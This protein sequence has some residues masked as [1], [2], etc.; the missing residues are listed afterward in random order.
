M[1]KSPSLHEMVKIHFDRIA[2][3]F[4]AAILF[5]GYLATLSPD[6]QWLDSSELQ[7]A[8][9]LLDNAHPPGEPL[10]AIIAHAMRFVPMGSLAFRITVFS[11]LCGVLSLLFVYA[12]LMQIT[13]LVLKKI[14]WQNRILA[15]GLTLFSAFSYALWVQTIRS[16]VYSLNFLLTTAI[17]YLSIR[18]LT[19]VISI[20]QE[21]NKDIR[22]CR[23]FKKEILL[24]AFLIGLGLGNHSLLIALMAPPIAF[25]LIFPHF[26]RLGWKGA[27]LCAFFF[28]VGLSVYLYQPLRASTSPPMNWGNPESLESVVWM[29]SGKMFQKSFHITLPA[30]VLNL[31]ETIF[32]LM[33]SLNPVLFFLGILG[34]WLNI[35]RHFI[36]GGFLISSL[37]FNL[38]SVVTQQVFIGTNPDLLGYLLFSNLILLVGINWSFTEAVHWLAAKKS[39]Q[40]AS[41]NT[42]IALVLLACLF[43]T[44]LKDRVKA[45]GSHNNYSAAIF[46]KAIL[47][48]ADPKS[49]IL[50]S[51]IGTYFTKGYLQNVE[52]YR[53]DIIVIHRPF[54]AFDWYVENLRKKHSAMRTIAPNLIK[55]IEDLIPHLQDRSI[56]FEL[57]L[58]LSDN[59]LPYISPSGLVFRYN[60]QPRS[61]DE[62]TLMRQR[63]RTKAVGALLTADKQDAEAL[64][65]VYWHHYCNGIF[66][67]KKGFYDQARWEFERCLAVTPN[68]SNIASL[69]RRV[70][71]ERDTGQ[72][73]N[74]N[75]MSKRISR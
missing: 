36:L 74:W 70:E 21:H 58:G 69:I 44:G 47:N 56:F 38:V 41:A 48:D 55:S 64:K 18:A 62:E 1:S 68:D 57:G 39:Q 3:G 65:T 37:V 40:V 19:A 8:A 27:F 66:Y 67:A 43:I 45:I 6:I 31:R 28:L 24:I 72:I 60:Q 15:L 42:I 71:R 30:L 73:G 26:S 63:A 10:Y 17:F 22:P 14:R 20:G 59:L 52:R 25:F 9:I 2:M 75:F 54:L 23:A 13:Y 5:A 32:I 51:N 49:Y 34:L 50:T 35:R 53:E 29:I 46:G 12:I 33:A 4:L 7:T 61:L 16:E 11:A